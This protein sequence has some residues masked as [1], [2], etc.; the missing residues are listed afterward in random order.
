MSNPYYN[1][2]SGGHSAPANTNTY[3]MS[4]FKY[5][6]EDDFVGFMNEIQDINL[7]LDNYGNL[8]ELIANKQK[9]HLQELDLDLNDAGDGEYAAKQIDALVLEASSLQ[10]ELKS[11]IKNV[12]TQ[13][14]QSHNPQKAAQ[15]ETT[16]NKFLDLI[17]RYRLAESNNREQ[18]KVQAERQY[19][20]VKPDATPEEIQAVVEDG[21]SNQQIFQQALMQSN[22]RGEARTVLNEVQVRHRELLKLEKTMAE[23]TQ[24]F[25]DMEEL[26]V[27]QDQPIQQIEE[28]IETAQH[29]IEQGVGHTNKAVVSAKKARKKK[30]WCFGITVLIL[31]ILGLILGLYFGLKK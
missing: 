26:V 16:R 11:R 4:A 7:Q 30:L 5:E 31:I 22:R 29:D 24:L 10:A 21:G 27:E 8:V 18:T 2:G 15:A 12:Q 6:E 13:A 28:Q 17:Q 20:I 23:L 1:N 3:E 9:N 19:R 14:A 25:H